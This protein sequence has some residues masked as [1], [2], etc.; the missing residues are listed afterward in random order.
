MRDQVDNLFKELKEILD[1]F[2]E[3]MIAFVAAKN[4]N[5]GESLFTKQHKL[6][7][8]MVLAIVFYT[9]L[10]TLGAIL[11]SR[12]NNTNLL[13][14]ITCGMLVFGSVVSVL[15]LCFISTTLAW[16]TVAMW[17]AMFTLVAYH[18]GVL[19]RIKNWMDRITQN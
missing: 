10:A 9:L 11:H 6:V 4:T 17:V 3:L 2:L 15:A 16:M 1:K 7:M 13:A 18:Y 5:T 19:Q 14:I 12:N 8:P